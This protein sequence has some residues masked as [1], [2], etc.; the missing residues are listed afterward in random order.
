MC[1]FVKVLYAPCSNH[2]SEHLIPEAPG[3]VGFSFIDQS[4][5]I[6]LQ[7]PVQ[8]GR[9]KETFPSLHLADCEHLQ[10]AALGRAFLHGASSVVQ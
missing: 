1:P 9:G 5:S 2:S 6:S 3:S 8:M 10:E 7:D 4:L